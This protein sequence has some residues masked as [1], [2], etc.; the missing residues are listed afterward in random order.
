MQQIGCR[1]AYS[2]HLCS[3]LFQEHWQAI[4]EPFFKIN[5]YSSHAGLGLSFAKRYATALGGS[6]E[7]AASQI[8]K[9]STFRFTLPN[10]VMTGSEGIPGAAEQRSLLSGRTFYMAK[11]PPPRDVVE[12]D[13]A[14]NLANFGCGRAAIADDAD[15]IVQDAGSASVSQEDATYLLRPKQVLLRLVSVATARNKTLLLS[16]SDGEKAGKVVYCYLPLYKKRL[17]GAIAALTQNLRC[18]PPGDYSPTASTGSDEGYDDGKRS[19]EEVSNEGCP[20]CPCGAS[21]TSSFWPSASG[22][23]CRRQRV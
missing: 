9:G 10:P 12:R 17:L 15:I 16:N 13:L 21:L 11:G 4:F 3:Q 19:R 23:A 7:V 2:L 18:V 8:G 5:P 1:Q 20:L 6:V 22:D 14:G